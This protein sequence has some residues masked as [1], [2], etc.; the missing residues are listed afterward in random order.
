M[1]VLVATTDGQ[2]DVADDYCWTVEGELVTP[3]GPA[4]SEPER[5]GCGRGFPGLAS[6]K[7]T[8]TAMVVERVGIDHAQV[9][10]ALQ[11]ALTREGWLQHLGADEAIEVVEEHL[12]A[13]EQVCRAF[14]IG[15]VVRRAGE[16]VFDRSQ[17]PPPQAR[18]A[19]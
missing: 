3:L 11:D 6:D 17:P 12:E 4:C 15:T 5:C 19:G 7:A 9:R 16:L 10:Q 2:G 14:P 8:S 1:R 18:R 13:I